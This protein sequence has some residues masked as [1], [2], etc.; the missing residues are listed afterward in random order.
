MATDVKI[1]IGVIVRKDDGLAIK[2]DALLPVTVL[3]DITSDE[4]L[5]KI[6]EKHHRFNQ[7]IV[8]HGN[9]A[10]YYLLY[11]EKNK[12]DTLPGSDETFRTQKV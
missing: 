7:I 9:K 4:L 1:N 2:R 8:K 5:S 3:D 11:G 6:A 12:A 10:F